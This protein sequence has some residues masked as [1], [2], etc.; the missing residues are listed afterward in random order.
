MGLPG[1]K[2]SGRAKRQRA[3]HFGLTKT[4]LRTCSQCNAPT[5]P[6]RAC[7][8]CGNYRGKKVVATEKRAAR[9]LKKK[10]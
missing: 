4:S 2:T 3:S 8:Q 1:H 5:L 6:H 9:A 7:T 10:R